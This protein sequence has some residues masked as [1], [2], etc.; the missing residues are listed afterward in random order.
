MSMVDAVDR[1]VHDVG[2]ESQ[3]LLLDELDDGDDVR[4]GHLGIERVVVHRVGEDA[5]L[6]A[7]RRVGGR[8]GAVRAPKQGREDPAGT[9]GAVGQT[10][11]P[12]GA[13]RPELPIVVVQR[14]DDPCWR[15]P[16]SAAAG[17]LG[18]S[19][20]HRAPRDG[21]VRR[22]PSPSCRPRSC[23]RGSGPKYPR[24]KPRCAG[25]PRCTCSLGRTAKGSN[26][27]TRIALRCVILSTSSS[28]IPLSDLPSS[29]G[30]CGHVL[31]ECG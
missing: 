4:D 23:V 29:S 13:A 21:Q 15:S 2:R 7:D 30:E 22:V 5:T 3:T 27:K 31:S 14:G 16:S 26:W 11:L 1:A 24:Q 20:R 10:Q 28:G 19:V 9:G 8:A 25:P 12:G 17:H 18:C 6:S